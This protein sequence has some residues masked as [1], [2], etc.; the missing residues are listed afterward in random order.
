MSLWKQRLF[1]TLIAFCPGLFSEIVVDGL[2]NEEEWSTA[3]VV[4]NFYEVYP[5][6]LETGHKDT[7][8]FIKEICLQ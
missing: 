5:Y 8:I 4:S 7:K 2:L 6:S 3:R 1:I